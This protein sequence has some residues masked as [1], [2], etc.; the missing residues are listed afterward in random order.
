MLV[1][2]C[3][4][5]MVCRVVPLLAGPLRAAPSWLW[6][7]VLWLGLCVAVVVYCM[8]FGSVCFELVRV[9]CFVVF[10]V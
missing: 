6:V 4:V 9:C 3:C 1:C 2:G 10:N 7:V 8:W 5:V